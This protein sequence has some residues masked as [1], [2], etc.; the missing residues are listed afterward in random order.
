VTR[1]P[2]PTYAAGALVALVSVASLSACG[3]DAPPAE[4]ARPTGDA[5]SSPSSSPTAGQSDSAGGSTPTPEPTPQVH[6]PAP[7]DAAGFGAVVDAGLDATQGADLTVESG[8]GLLSGEGRIDFRQDPAAL[9]MSLTSS[10]TGDGQPIDLRVV[11][12]VLYLSDG[13]RYLGVG[14][15]SPGNPFGASLTDQLD[16]RTVLAAVQEAFRSGQDRGPVEEDGEQL[17]VYRAAADAGAVLGRI[18]PDLADQ[19]D[20]VLPD[21]VVADVSVDADGLARRIQVDLGAENGVLTYTLEGWSEDVVV[22]A[23][24]ASQVDDLS[25]PG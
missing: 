3:G 4:S 17:T 12:E 21:E 11:D 16:P 13:A 25:L 8:L 24:P 7:L 9:E 14:V 18:A 20:T 22:D 6:Q 23:P 5:T 19:P 1:R 2:R 10:E 15:D